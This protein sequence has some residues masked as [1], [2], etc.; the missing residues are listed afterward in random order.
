M[1]SA[2]TWATIRGTM[3]RDPDGRG[4]PWLQVFARPPA[5]VNITGWPR[6]VLL[7]L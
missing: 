3:V 2:Q 7:V 1:V 5:I 6:E 4:E